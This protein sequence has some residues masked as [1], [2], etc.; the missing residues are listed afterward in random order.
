MGIGERERE[1]DGILRL[2]SLYKK[3]LFPKLFPHVA[4]TDAHPVTHAQIAHAMSVN[5]ATSCLFS[6]PIQAQSRARIYM[7]ADLYIC[8]T[9]APCSYLTIHISIRIHD[10][11]AVWKMHCDLTRSLAHA[12]LTLSV[13]PGALHRKGSNSVINLD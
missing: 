2:Y 13:S 12:A 4:W 5:P 1:R 7:Q 11:R 9:L 10:R 8:I 6:I 3:L